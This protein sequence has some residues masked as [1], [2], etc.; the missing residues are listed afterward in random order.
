M[1]RRD[2][3]W[4]VF[5]LLTLWQVMAML[6]NQ[7]ILPSPFAVAQAFVK[8][9]ASGDLLVHFLASLWRVLASTILA[10]VLAVPAGLVLG[11]R[12][13]GAKTNEILHDGNL[14]SKYLLW[15]LASTAYL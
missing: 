14:S 1:N 3:T 8:E 2:L 7:P 12:V 10:I 13:V 15:R 6:I 9:L 11:Q 5:G 4:S